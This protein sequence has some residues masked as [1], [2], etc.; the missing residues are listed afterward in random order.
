MNRSLPR[1]DL[2]SRYSS[3]SSTPRS[4]GSSKTDSPV[5][6]LHL[7][8]A[9]LLCVALPPD[10]LPL[11]DNTVGTPRTG[12]PLFSLMSACSAVVF[13][14]SSYLA[15]STARARKQKIRA[16]SRSAARSMP[17]PVDWDA[18]NCLLYATDFGIH[19][20]IY[21]IASTASSLG[22][23]TRHGSGAR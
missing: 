7:F 1:T 14:L 10:V 17:M 3:S 22:G 8:R 16:R 18:G 5:L 21:S 20:A 2:S 4:R 19:V 12:W 13:L 11:G 6:S 15:L 23:A 9:A